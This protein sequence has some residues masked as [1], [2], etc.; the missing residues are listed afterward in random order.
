MMFSISGGNSRGETSQTVGVTRAADNNGEG[1]HLNSGKF[2]S[3]TMSSMLIP[4]YL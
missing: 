3:N 2:W 4:M 1:H